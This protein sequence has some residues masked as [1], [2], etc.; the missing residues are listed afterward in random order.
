M[1]ELVMSRKQQIEK[2]ATSLFKAKGFSATSMRDLATALGMEAAS[3]YSHIKSKEE[4]L[5]QVCF[6]MADKFFEAL[7]TANAPDASATRQLKLAIAA[8]VEV[9][10]LNTEASAVFLYEWRHLSEPFH[11]TFLGLRDTYEARFREI[12]RLGIQN[13][14]FAVPDEKFA[15][16]TILS[17]LNWIHTWYKP[18]GK[19]TPGQIAENLSEMLLHGLRSEQSIT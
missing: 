13:G 8:H 1:D 7:Q 11:G 5:Q 17:A 10:T 4:I 9:L 15:A 19:M 6:Q 3:I 18:T 16:L 14:E 2:T 12:I